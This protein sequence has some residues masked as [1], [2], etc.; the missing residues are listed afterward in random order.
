MESTVRR[1]LADRIWQWR[2]AVYALSAVAVGLALLVVFLSI[3]SPPTL[4]L[5]SEPIFFDSNRTFRTA[6]ELSRLYPDRTMGSADA[7]GAVAW[8]Q[9]RL[10]AMKIPQTTRRYPVSLGGN[11]VTLTDIAVFL[12]GSGSDT[13]LVSAPRDPGPFEPSGPLGQASG[14]AMLLEFIQVFASRPHDKSFLLVSTEGADYSGLG[15]ARFLGSD[16]RAGQIVTGISLESLGRERLEELQ[17]EIVG[18]RNATPGWLVNLT[19]ASLDRAGYRLL[20]PGLLDQIAIHALALPQGEQVAALREGIPALLLHGVATDEGTVTPAGL[21]TQGVAIERLLLSIDAGTELPADPGTALV[22]GAG[23]YLTLS[24]LTTLALV[25]LLPSLAMAA[26]WLI[27]TRMRPEGWM[28]FLRNLVSF[29]LPMAAILAVAWLAGVAGII[30]RF[31]YQAPLG[32]PIATE[33]QVLPSALLFLTAL[34]FVFLSRHFLGYLR[35]RE[36][37]VMAEMGKLSIGL[38]ALVAGLALLMSH[39]PF[40]LLTG[41][42]AAWLWPLVTCFSEPRP[43]TISWVPTLRSN[44]AL[45]LA[46]LVAPVLLYLYLAFDAAVGLLRGWWFLLVQ[47][48]SGAYGLRGP[49]A[50]ILITSGLLVLLGVKRLT[51][52]PIETLEATDELDLVQAPVR[53]A[54][55][56]RR[57][58]VTQRPGQPT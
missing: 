24:A 41:I 33:P 19:Q 15:L 28:R 56:S 39:S 22:V 6:Q 47:T 20:L 52:I 16:A 21:G 14:T 17:A 12:P 27:S 34:A 18:P 13:V 35:P 36:P 30:P 55:R 8:Y 31:P 4:E 50:S 51:L 26:T 58:A 32:N 43:A 45:L 38:A 48:V 10:K 57:T 9:E 54:R 37:L 25:M 1:R 29:A 23:R 53:R 42:T 5:S 46:G 2:K 40:S 11:K 7:A 49:A 44:A 3:A